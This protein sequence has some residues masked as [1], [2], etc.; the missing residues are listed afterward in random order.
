MSGIQQT[1]LRIPDAWSASWF[2]TFVTEV[3]AKADI[4]NAIGQGVTITSNGNSVATISA[5]A[6]TAGAVSAHNVDPL[7]HADA[8][9]A[10]RA[11]SDPHPQYAPGGSD[12]Q[13]Q[14]NDAGA[15]GASENLTFLLNDPDWGSTQLRAYDGSGLSSAVLRAVADDFDGWVA[16]DSF[17]TWTDVV[18]GL[19]RYG[20]GGGLWL[21]RGRGSNAAREDVQVGDA[22]GVIKFAGICGASNTF[23]APGH[24]GCEVKEI[25]TYIGANI[26]FGTKP[27]ATANPIYRMRLDADGGVVLRATATVDATGGSMGAGTINAAGLYVDGVAVGTSFDQI[28]TAGFEILVDGDG[29]VVTE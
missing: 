27:M 14:F 19:Q 24:I 2:R 15:F 23:D 22:L 6:E 16:A 5:D 21:G 17:N 11:E 20:G 12:T 25:G 8:F 18:N 1:P 29:N 7:A 13:V 28:L 9:A 26:V 3:I 4:R 10:H